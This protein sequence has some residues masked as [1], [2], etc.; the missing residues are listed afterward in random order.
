MLLNRLKMLLT[1][2]AAD[3]AFSTASDD[4]AAVEL[5]TDARLERLELLAR[6]D[7]AEVTALEAV[8]EMVL[9]DPLTRPLAKSVK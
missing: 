7:R 2:V 4:F 5:A 9:E 3:F 6:D 1:D 8:E